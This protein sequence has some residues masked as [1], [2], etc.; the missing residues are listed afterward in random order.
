MSVGQPFA[1]TAD[2]SSSGAAEPQRIAAKLDGI[3]PIRIDQVDQRRK[4]GL[5][6]QAKWIAKLGW[7]SWDIL[8]PKPGFQVFF[9][10]GNSK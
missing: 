4:E 2:D 5:F 9:G 3:T 10:L 6:Q 8:N 1:K 7:F